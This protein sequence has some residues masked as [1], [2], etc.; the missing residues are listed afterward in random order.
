VKN[1]TIFFPALVLTVIGLFVL[2]SISKSLFPTYYF[3]VLVGLALY[4]VISR[5]DFEIFGLFS[6]HFYVLG[7]VGLVIPLVFGRITH[8]AIRWIQIGNV[9]IQPSELVRPFLY[10]FMAHFLSR[11]VSAKRTIYSFLFV[12]L[13]VLLILVQ[14][15][16]TVALLTTT[17]FLGCLLALKI[18]FKLLGFILLAFAFLAFTFLALSKP[19][20]KERLTSFLNYYNDPLGSGYNSIQAVISVGSGGLLGKGFGKGTQTQLAF[21]PE[22]H[23]DFIVASIGEEFGVL[24]ILVILLLFIAILYQIL[25]AHDRSTD[26]AY[27]AYCLAVFVVLSVQLTINVLMNLGLFPVA[28]V[29]FPLVSY[30][31]SS[32]IATM[33][34]LGLVSSGR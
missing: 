7:L 14:P 4:L 16:L 23:N 6:R 31:G 20:Q 19:Y 13:Y 18:N 34:M 30:G 21:L 33:M 17:G 26:Q 28:G 15:S 22:K 5:V 2:N 9:S 1:K 8:G 3:Y 10:L 32:Y 12:G 29:N 25:E 11:T 24:G 27:R